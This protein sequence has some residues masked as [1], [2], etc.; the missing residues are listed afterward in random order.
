MTKDKKG[1]FYP[2]VNNSLCI[3]CRL[4]N[5]N[6]AF[7]NKYESP[8]EPLSYLSLK[9]KDRKI[10]L[11]SSSGGVFHSVASNFIKN[12]GVVYGAV[13]DC[14][15]KTIK[16]VKATN[17]SELGP[18]MGSKYV[19]SN[20]NGV[21]LE[22]KNHL[23]SGKKVL[24]VGT[25]CQNAQLF[26]STRGISENLFLVDLM[27]H[28]VPSPLIFEEH[29]KMWEA[30][31]KSRII[32][33]KF[34]SKKYGYEY[35]HTAFFENGKKDS[36]I[37]LKRILKL[38]EYTMRD[39]CYHCP[40][41]SKNRF[42]DITIGDLWEAYRLIGDFDHRGTSVVLI[43]SEKGNKML[44]DVS[45]DFII[46]ALS[47]DNIKQDCLSKPVEWKNANQRFWEDYSS[48]GY[49]FVLDKYGKSTFKSKVYQSLLR[50]LYKTRLDG[51]Y[52]RL[53][54]KLKK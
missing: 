50:L 18:M 8:N 24:F 13:F 20:T 44:E 48:F 11:N 46:H 3:N 35:N 51:F 32:D 5:S 16:H 38:Y 10:L 12:G 15:T 17:V 21:L 1:F 36:S 14:L 19:Q 4:C 7:L 29:I 6:C 22:I 39:S 47:P 54:A 23:I 28:G 26:F 42:G 34:R 41:T 9:N 2:L 45:N 30:K 49:R 37:E 25:P 53:R 52:L 40:Y 33:Y 43:N 31:K 27:C